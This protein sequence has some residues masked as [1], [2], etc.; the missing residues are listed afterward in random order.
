MESVD[1]TQTFIAVAEDCPAE[2]GTVPPARKNGPS[3]AE[4]TYRLI[5]SAPY[6]LTSADV[7]FTVHADRNEIPAD[8]RA[9][10]RA[11]FFAKPQPCLRASDLGKR[12]GW[13]IHA[14]EH[15]RLALVGRETPEYQ[16]LSAG[17][18]PE[19]G[20]VTVVKAM[21]SARRSG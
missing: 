2:A 16:Q 3:V 13:G 7:L 17:R 8:E 11:A 6:A 1:Y 9:A 10:A 15:G 12:Y 4:R 14:D 19:G 5:A 21:R 18:T 20:E